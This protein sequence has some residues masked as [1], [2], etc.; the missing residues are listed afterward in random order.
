[1][2]IPS[3]PGVSGSDK[4]AADLA[5]SV[6]A[7][8]IAAA[9]PGKAFSV[10]GPMNLVLYGERTATLTTAA[11]SFSASVGS[12]TGL[13]NGAA[14]KSANVPA[15][16]A[17]G[18][19]SGTNLTLVPPPQFWNGTL[20]PGTTGI[21]MGAL[22]ADLSVLVGATVVSPYF[23]AGTTVTAIDAA[24]RIATT[25]NAPTGL[26]GVVANFLFEFDPDPSVIVVTGA[27]PAATFTGASIFFNATVQLER[28]FDGGAT[29]IACNIGGSGA[30]AQ[31]V[32]DGSTTGTPISLAFGDP[33]A[34]MLYR[35]NALAFSAVSNVALKYRISTTGQ[36]GTSISLQTI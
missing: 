12:A 15:G 13:A 3:L 27:D 19:L 11:N 23:A 36:A 5:T 25:S 10:Y 20:R 2:G 9:G 22:P 8:T 26:P 6:V 16:T 34:G 28:S 4:V 35:L 32:G 18:G 31:W 33:E 24:T 17:L 14:I 30:L 7:G 21:Y 1:M 29:W